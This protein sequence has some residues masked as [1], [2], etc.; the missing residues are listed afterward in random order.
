MTDWRLIDENTPKDRRILLCNGKVVACGR[1][2]EGLY[3]R[4]WRLDDG[5]VHHVTHW[6]PITHPSV[7]G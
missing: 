2:V 5:K 7:L 6:S 1:W 4:G 3:Q